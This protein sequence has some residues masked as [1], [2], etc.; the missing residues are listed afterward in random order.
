LLPFFCQE[1]KGSGGYR[2]YVHCKIMFGQS[3]ENPITQ[4]DSHLNGM[5]KWIIIYINP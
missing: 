2:D 1:K 4:K 3:P 5:L